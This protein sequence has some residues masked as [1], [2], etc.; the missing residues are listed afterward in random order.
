MLPPTGQ[1]KILFSIANQSTKPK[2][3]TS[4]GPDIQMALVSSTAC[5][6]FC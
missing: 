4:A 6:F 3:T 1:R 5:A 2:A